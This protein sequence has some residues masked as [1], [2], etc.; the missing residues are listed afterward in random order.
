MNQLLIIFSYIVGATLIALFQCILIEL[1]KTIK[2]IFKHYRFYHYL[3][4]VVTLLLLFA[5]F[6]LCALIWAI[7][8]YYFYDI[9]NTFHDC[10]VFSIDSFSTLGSSIELDKPYTLL[11]PVIAIIG[12]SSIA[13]ITSTSFGIISSDIEHKS[14]FSRLE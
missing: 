4:V 7:I 5:D 2:K 12:I 10:V 14:L 9:F 1:I 3:L 13:F 8:M 6:Y 11:G